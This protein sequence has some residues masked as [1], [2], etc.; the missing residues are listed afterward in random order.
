MFTDG[1]TA[2][3]HNT[4]VSPKRTYIKEKAMKFLQCLV[5][6]GMNQECQHFY[7]ACL[8]RMFRASGIK[9]K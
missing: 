6:A 9:L 8:D 3:C 7:E 2:P 4:S 1:R 5:Q